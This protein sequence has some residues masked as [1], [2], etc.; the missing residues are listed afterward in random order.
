MG[1]IIVNEDATMSLTSTAGSDTQTVCTINEILPITY[2]ITGS[3]T[4]VKVIG[5]PSGVLGTFSQGYFSINGIPKVAGSKILCTPGFP[6]PPP[7]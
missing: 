3:V 7:T 6:K 2:S 4:D 1:T 5:L